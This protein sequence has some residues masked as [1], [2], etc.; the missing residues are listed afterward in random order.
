MSR[1]DYQGIIDTYRQLQAEANQA[2][3]QRYQDIL[4]VMTGTEEAAVRVIGAAL[5]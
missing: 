1:F 4:G 3:E 5:K 2:N